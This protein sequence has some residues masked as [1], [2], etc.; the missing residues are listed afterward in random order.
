M[1][2]ALSSC[3][4][5]AKKPI[6]S[7]YEPPK[8]SEP[9]NP[10]NS[11]NYLKIIEQTDFLSLPNQAS[12]N[13]SCAT[14]TQ[15]PG[16]NYNDIFFDIV[17]LDDKAGSQIDLN[18]R[19]L[20]DN[21]TEAVRDYKLTKNSCKK[22]VFNTKD[23]LIRIA[24]SDPNNKYRRDYKISLKNQD[25][26]S[27]GQKCRIM[28][29]TSG[30]TN[31]TDVVI[32]IDCR[33]PVV[34]KSFIPK[35]QLIAFSAG[36]F[37]L[38]KPKVEAEGA[39]DILRPSFT[40]KSSDI[41]T[42]TID[43]TSGK[44]TFNQPGKVK[45]SLSASEDFYTSATLEYF[46][47]AKDLPIKIQQLEIGQS[48]ILPIGAK[49][50]IIAPNNKT[51]VRAL[52][53]SPTNEPLRKA[54]LVITSDKGETRLALRCPTSLNTNAFA[55]NHYQLSDSCYAILAS[56]AELKNLRPYSLLKF[57][58]NEINTYAI[59]NVSKE[60]KLDIT[61]VKGK[62]FRGEANIPTHTA[63]EK[64][65]RQ[66]FPLSEISIKTRQNSPT[67]TTDDNLSSALKAIDK[68]R[69]QE[70]QNRHYYGFVRANSCGG[71]VGLG[72]VGHPS[73]VG[74]DTSA[75]GSPA[76]KETMMHE[77]GHNLGLGHA[78][79]GTNSGISDPFWSSNAYGGSNN[80][81]LNKNPLF[82][83]ATEEVKS[84]LNSSAHQGKER[85]LMA[86]CK[87]TRLS[88]HHYAMVTNFMQADSKYKA[89]AYK[90]SDDLN[91][92]KLAQQKPKYQ[93]IISGEILYD[94]DTIVLDPI[95]LT[96]NNLVENYYLNPFGYMLEVRTTKTRAKYPLQI[97][98]LDHSKLMRFKLV[99]PIEDIDDKIQELI[100]TQGDKKIPYRINNSLNSVSPTL[101]KTQKQ[102]PPE[103]L[104][105][106]QMLAAS[107]QKNPELDPNKLADFKENSIVWNAQK[108]P[109]M[110]SVFI[111][112]DG[113]RELLTSQAEGGFFQL[114][115]KL[116]A[117]RLEIYLSDGVN[118]KL[119][120]MIRD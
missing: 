77:L 78:P 107:M 49:E 113:T 64:Q 12:A 14:P 89:S 70:D 25:I 81:E 102:A 48:S 111:A 28:S 47:E 94:T 84:P 2:F 33:T 29:P 57:E 20:Q 106:A 1:L 75:C 103:F 26:S 85:D 74:L 73:A 15:T 55:Q 69:N 110:T 18:V 104:A 99:L 16:A 43:A 11:N 31:F 40:Y 27:N 115:Q 101:A 88:N 42:A 30:K 62:N 10:V 91:R 17:G 5:S 21:W 117:G 54:N 68:L 92:Q 19:L 86:Y 76:L 112:E 58:F 95:E 52:V 97:L 7:S 63:I 39:R 45:I 116:T 4:F 3:D 56:Q 82:I 46:I 61:L 72:H 118:N 65:L 6:D 44:L 22:F 93:R 9:E 13:Y 79:C 114:E 36:G 71:T 8:P 67:L 105:K 119:V 66:V 87:G 90:V 34:L 60:F 50:Q 98:Q 23:G 53:Y 120:L 35:E 80:A 109:F 51:L 24:N 96:S 100:F 41:S 37:Y 108:Y 83:Q 59:A 32:K 38:P